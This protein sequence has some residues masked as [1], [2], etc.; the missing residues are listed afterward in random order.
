LGGK[1]EGGGGVGRKNVFWGERGGVAKEAQR[2]NKGG[3]FQVGVESE[4]GREEASC[5]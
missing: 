4:K 2:G 1:G 5:V 3:G